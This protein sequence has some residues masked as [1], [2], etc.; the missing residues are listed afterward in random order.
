MGHR[1]LL[2]VGL[3]EDLLHRVQVLILAGGE[4]QPHD[5]RTVLRGHD[6]A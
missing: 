6:V 3:L 2:A 1:T 5:R 4:T